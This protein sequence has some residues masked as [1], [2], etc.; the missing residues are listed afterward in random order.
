MTDTVAKKKRQVKARSRATV[1]AANRAKAVE[2]RKR[3]QTYEKIAK[4]LGMTKQSVHA[5]V[6]KA[7]AEV[8]VLQDKDA[9]VLK[10][11]ELENLDAL[12]NAAWPRAMKGSVLHIGQILKIQERRAKLAGLDAPT[13]VANTDAQGNDLDRD[14]LKDMSDEEIQ[15]RI[16]ELRASNERQR[17]H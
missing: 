2:L 8:K 3:G 4:T 5:H 14:R 1:S 16:D 10:T 6:R 15:A 12:Q 17:V 9:E 13:K 11:I 7:M